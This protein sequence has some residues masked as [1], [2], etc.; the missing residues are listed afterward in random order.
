MEKKCDKCL[1]E[2]K[3]HTHS[4]QR[5]EKI[6]H[7]EMGSAQVILLENYNYEV[8]MKGVV[9]AYYGVFSLTVKGLI[10]GYHVLQRKNTLL[11]DKN[12]KSKEVFNPS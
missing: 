6:F 9:A 10:L 8:T 4:L 12:R 5:L 7:K 1:F 2:Q 11:M 3:L